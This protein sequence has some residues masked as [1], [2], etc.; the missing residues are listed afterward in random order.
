MMKCIY[1]NL[2]DQYIEGEL[3]ETDE[4]KLREHVTTCAGC[5]EEWKQAEGLK[6]LIEEAHQPVTASQIAAN[7]IMNRIRSDMRIAGTPRSRFHSRELYHGRV[8]IPALAAACL[9]IGA[10]LGGFVATTVARSGL[11]V[12]AIPVQIAIERVSGTVL[13]RHAEG[14]RWI[15]LTPASRLYKGD[16]LL[17]S[18]ESRLDLKLQN[19]S[20][21]SIEPNSMLRLNR[22]DGS[23]E[24]ALDRGALVADL[25]S[26]HPQFVIQ[27]PDGA[28]QALGTKFRV[29]VK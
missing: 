29:N 23:A 7:Q 6:V 28:I 26:P 25:E 12:R 8:R 22:Y 27:T 2:I 9:V 15:E 11:F 21:L 19:N 13:V 1:R 10:L 5:R 14:D 3:A 17:C 4:L 24:F 20:R 16:L 18:A